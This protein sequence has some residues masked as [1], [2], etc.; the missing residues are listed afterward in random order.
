MLMSARRLYNQIFRVGTQS[1][2]AQADSSL[3]C[4]C[5]LHTPAFLT[6]LQY[7][8]NAVT[9]AVVMLRQCSPDE[10]LSDLLQS[11]RLS[12]LVSRIV[13]EMKEKLGGSQQASLGEEQANKQPPSSRGKY[14]KRAT[15]KSLTTMPLLKEE[16]QG[17]AGQSEQSDAAVQRSRLATLKSIS[18]ASGTMKRRKATLSRSLDNANTKVEVA[19]GDQTTGVYK[20]QPTIWPAAAV[21]VRDPTR[22]REVISSL[23]LRQQ[24]D[25]WRE[26]DIAMWPFSSCMREFTLA[27][28][29]TEKARAVESAFRSLYALLDYYQ[30]RDNSPTVLYAPCHTVHVV[31]C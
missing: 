17:Q 26:V 25:S 14:K 24:N 27:T 6:L 21:V 12:R 20:H 13:A 28:N 19:D 11:Q 31:S 3:L 30:E 5:H 7:E 29:V 23:P 16:E 9:E 15:L 8:S 22:W 10:V 1:C 2:R 18:I 4:D